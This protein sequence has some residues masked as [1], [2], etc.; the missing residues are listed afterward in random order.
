M[1]S[2]IVGIPIFE[3]DGQRPISTV[4]DVIMD[5]ERGKAVALV[6]DINQNKVITPHDI[7][8]LGDILKI[9]GREVIIDGSDVIRVEEIQKRNVRILNNRVETKEGEYLGKVVDYSLELSGLNLQKIYVAKGFMGVVRYGGRMIPAKKIVEVL[10]KKIV[11][12][13][14]LKKV[15]EKKMERGL[16]DV[17]VG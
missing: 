9:R 7:L 3:E 10:P 11:V 16:S 17:A 2:N 15:K 5:P 6:V 14:G 8:S 13:N 1:Y 4:K 12:E